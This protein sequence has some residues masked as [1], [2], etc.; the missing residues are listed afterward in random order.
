MAIKRRW[1]FGSND[2]G[3]YLSCEKC[4]HKLSAKQ[5]VFAK[6][7][8][9]K[10]PWCNSTMEISQKD[11]DRLKEGLRERGGGELIG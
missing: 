5:V 7:S 2:L 10:C 11:Y 3:D 9:N 4:G 1:V 6:V 8:Y